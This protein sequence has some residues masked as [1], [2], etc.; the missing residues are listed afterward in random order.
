M[1]ECNELASA[2]LV[3]FGQVEVLEVEDEVLA[4]PGAVDPPSGGGYGHAHLNN[5]TK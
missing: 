1:Q 4:V 2:P 5:T 3:R